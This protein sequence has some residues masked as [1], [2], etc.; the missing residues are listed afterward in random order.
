MTEEWDIIAL[1]NVQEA[2]I[3]CGKNQQRQLD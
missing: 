3:F 2:A 1:M